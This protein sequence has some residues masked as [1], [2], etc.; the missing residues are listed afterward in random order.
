MQ[1]VKYKDTEFEIKPNRLGVGKVVSEIASAYEDELFIRK[2]MVTKMKDYPEY[3]NIL[4]EISMINAD[5]QEH[6]KLLGKSK[7]KKKIQGIITANKKNLEKEYRRL[8]A[9]AM[10]IIANREMNINKEV[11]YGFINDADVFKKLC[12]TLLKGDHSKIIFDDLDKDLIGLRD[13]VYKTF[14]T[15]KASI[16]K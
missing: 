15:I 10:A 7:D 3:N 11:H 5:L 9:P 1:T 2:M 4:G 12:E 13:E 6:E 14:F 16:Y 8:S